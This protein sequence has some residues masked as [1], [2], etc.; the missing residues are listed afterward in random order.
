MKRKTRQIKNKKICTYTAIFEPAEEGGYVV[1]VPRLP[2]CITQGETFEG[3][4][5]MAKDAISLYLKTLQEDGE[6]IPIEKDE[7][8]EV[9]IPVKVPA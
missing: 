2:G 4:K 5:K 3:A 1:T 9:H 6:E 8:I 7:W